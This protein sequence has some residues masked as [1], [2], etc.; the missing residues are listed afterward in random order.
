[1]YRILKKKSLNPTVT[2]MAVSYT[3]LD[4]Y[5][6]QLY[7]YYTR[8]QALYQGMKKVGAPASNN[9]VVNLVLAL[10][11]LSIV[12]DALIQNDL[13]KAAGVLQVRSQTV[14]AE[15]ENSVF[16]NEEDTAQVP[17]EDKAEPA[18][19]NVALLRQLAELHD[20]G[21]LSDEEFEAKKQDLLDR[22]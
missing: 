12:S 18:A 17:S 13:N 3:H 15:A 7:W 11:G 9:S 8:G 10:F 4:V 2:L 21:I 19:K 6:R 14:L 1:M 20:K 5:K 16:S 22:I